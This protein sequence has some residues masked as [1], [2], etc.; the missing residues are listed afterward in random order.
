[1]VVAQRGVRPCGRQ[2]PRQA[3]PARRVPGS[4]RRRLTS[5]RRNLGHSP[6]SQRTQ[7]VLDV[8]SGGTPDDARGAVADAF[9]TDTSTIERWEHEL[10]GGFRNDWLPVQVFDPKHQRA[11]ARLRIELR[12]KELADAV[13]DGANVEAD[14]PERL[15][16]SNIL[17]AV[18]HALDHLPVGLPMLEQLELT[19]VAYTDEHQPYVLVPKDK[20][21]RQLKQERNRLSG[22]KAHFLDVIEDALGTLATGYPLGNQSKLGKAALDA[23]IDGPGRR[24]P[25]LDKTD[26]VS[27]LVHAVTRRILAFLEET[28]PLASVLPVRSPQYRHEAVAAAVNYAVTRLL[29]ARK[30]GEAIVY[31]LGG[32]SWGNHKNFF[33]PRTPR[34]RPPTRLIE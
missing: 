34:P 31:V 8:Y 30:L 33:G 6:Q 17:L 13:W 9:G 11:V 29:G 7:A 27:V 2:A 23:I 4:A 19:S 5:C 20:P 22:V 16:F 24:R 1:M 21:F 25:R 18:R 26:E 14:R 28:Q 12:L 10:L 32:V 3:S 15:C